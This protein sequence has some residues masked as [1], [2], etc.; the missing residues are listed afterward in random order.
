MYQINKLIYKYRQKNKMTQQEVADKMGLTTY[1]FV[2]NIERNKAFLSEKEALKF[3]K[4]LNIPDKIIINTLK[5]TTESKYLNA[6][7]RDNL[8]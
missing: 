2:S 7:M 1:Q 6:I 8:F 4:A 3:A 5:K